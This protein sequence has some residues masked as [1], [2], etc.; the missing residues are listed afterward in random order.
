MP[1]IF[2]GYFVFRQKDQYNR[3][4][5]DR[6]TR[7]SVSFISFGKKVRPDLVNHELVKQCLRSIGSIGANYRE[8]NESTSKKDFIY[9]LKI[10]RKEAKESLYWIDLLLVANPSRSDELL[11][12]KDECNQ[13]FKIFC[14][15]IYN[16]ESL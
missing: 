7:L 4:L 15:I 6:T 8:A 9:R 16:L 1:R 2:M 11:S 13:I 12:I 14:K 5:E 3:R 10:V